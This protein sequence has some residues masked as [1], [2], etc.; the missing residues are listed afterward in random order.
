M[1]STDPWDGPNDAVTWPQLGVGRGAFNLPGDFCKPVPNNNCQII[2]QVTYGYV[3]KSSYNGN[4]D[5]S[6]VPVENMEEK[7][8]NATPAICRVGR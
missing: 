4:G 1:Q 7:T 2:T 8:P 3:T 5:C 6:T